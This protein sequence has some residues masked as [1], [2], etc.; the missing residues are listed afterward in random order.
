LTIGGAPPHTPLGGGNLFAKG[1]TTEENFFE[2][3]FPPS[4]LSKNF[5]KFID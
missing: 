2:K 1:R 5:G 4:P 3:S